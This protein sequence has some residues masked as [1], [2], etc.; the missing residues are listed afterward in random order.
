MES[1]AVW[2]GEHIDSTEI[3]WYF[4]TIENKLTA[5]TRHLLET[6]SNIS[7]PEVLP[8]VYAIVSYLP[9]FDMSTMFITV[10]IARQGMEGSFL[11]VHRSG[12]VP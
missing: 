2:S 11:Y 9:Q 6:Y 12:S 8:H 3:V 7:P 10:P 4:P 1:D 5:D